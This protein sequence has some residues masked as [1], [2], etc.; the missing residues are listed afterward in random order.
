MTIIDLVEKRGWFVFPLRANTRLPY[1]NFAWRRRSTNNIDLI[2]RWQTQSGGCNWGVDCG[3]SKLLVMDIDIKKGKTGYDSILSLE[4]QGFKL[5][6]T[7]E[8]STT[9]GGAHLYYANTEKVKNSVEILGSGLDTRG[10]GGYV[11]A[12]YSEINGKFYEITDDSK[13]TILPKWII[14]KIGAKNEIDKPKDRSR[15]AD[16][17]DNYTYLD[18]PESIIEGVSYLKRAPRS[19]EGEGGDNNSYKVACRVRDYGISENTAMRL[20]FEFWNDDCSPPWSYEKLQSKIAHAYKYAEEKIGVSSIREIFSGAVD[21]GEVEISGKK[22][23]S[24]EKDILLQILPFSEMIDTP[25]PA[26]EWVIDEWLPTNTG[27]FL[28]GAGGAG[29]S[30]VAM[31]LAFSVAYGL[32]WFGLPVATEMPVIML[33]CEDSK[34]EIHRRS[35]SIRLSSEYREGIDKKKSHMKLNF[36]TRLGMDNTLAIAK[37]FSLKRGSLYEKILR[38]TDQFPNQPKLL[39][40]DTITD[41]FKGNENDRSSVNQFVKEILGEFIVN[42]NCTVLS[43]GHPPKNGAEYSGSTAWENSHRARLFLN[44]HGKDKTAL[45]DYRIMTNSKSNYSRVGGEINMIYAKGTYNLVSQDEIHDDVESGLLEIIKSVI[46]KHSD[47]GRALGM[48]NRAN[49]CFEALETKDEEGKIINWNE[50]RR[51]VNKLKVMD[52]IIE[53]RGI[54]RRNGLHLTE[55]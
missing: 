16:T 13:I 26:R 22:E 40:F 25:A 27:I 32:P 54:P 10:A 6:V 52:E 36:L 12:P 47:A 37:D 24:K 34:S 31:Q 2:K 23:N 3:K 39:I 20:M 44:G 17:G 45:A 1:S 43:I 53:I 55:K 41:I 5:P 11:V 35:R 30:L 28:T 8:V 14:E 48:H 49:Y 21:I 9:T 18:T 4:T 50:K 38:L 19:T 51:L 15:S 33:M 7:F 42:H 29:K 46:S